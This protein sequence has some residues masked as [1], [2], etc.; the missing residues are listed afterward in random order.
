MVSTRR[1]IGALCLLLCSC[2]TAQTILATCDELGEAI[3]VNDAGSMEF[4]M[5]ENFEC[6]GST[7]SIGSGDVTI[8]GRGY[9]MKIGETFSPSDGS[10]IGG[11]LFANENGG[12]LTLRNIVFID[13]GAVSTVSPL[14]IR[15]VRNEGALVVEGCTFLKL[16]QGVEGTGEYG[17]AIYTAGVNNDDS[18]AVTIRGSLFESNVATVAGGAI[19]ATGSDAV[20][21]EDSVFKMNE[22]AN[23][24]NQIAMGGGIFA[25]SMVPLTVTNSSFSSNTAESAGSAIYLC[26]G[27]LVHSTFMRHETFGDVDGESYGAVT[28]KNNLGEGEGCEPLIVSNCSFNSNS[29]SGGIGGALAVFNGELE[30]MDTDF[31]SNQGG[32]VYFSSSNGDGRDTIEMVNCGFLYNTAPFLQLEDDRMLGTAVLVENTYEDGLSVEMGTFDTIACFRNKPYECEWVEHQIESMHLGPFT[33]NACTKDGVSLVFKDDSIGGDDGGDDDN[34]RS[35]T[36]GDSSSDTSSGVVVGLAVALGFV[37]V[38]VVALGAW[39][40]RVKRRSRRLLDGLNYDDN[41]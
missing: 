10:D 27:N 21:V 2:T 32:A 19:F 16:N 17:G 6:T 31:E 28:S 8:E 3:I 4:Q 7:M 12:T 39:K 29:L 25:D 38:A 1:A 22:A 36:P 13:A 33:C 40:I 26:G 24:D 23:E 35:V 34:L 5:D 37:L 15:A 11:S 18:V 14:N 41:L 30:V 9:S 20:T